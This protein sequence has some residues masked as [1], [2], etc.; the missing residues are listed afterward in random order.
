MALVFGAAA[1][2]LLPKALGVGF[3]VLL[4]TL[5]VVATRP[6]FA[7]S[8]LYA[9]AAGAVEDSIS[10]LPFMTSASCFLLVV[11]LVRWSRLPSVVAA[12]VFPAYQIWLC[13]WVTGLQGSVFG[14]VLVAIP[15]G[16]LAYGVVGPLLAAVERRAAVDEEG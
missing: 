4:A 5:P 1:E 7:L 9:L 8:V 2:E 10:G 11:A 3:P 15:F 16:I 6:P 14:R 13:L 12:V